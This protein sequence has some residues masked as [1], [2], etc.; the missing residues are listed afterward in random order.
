MFQ[1]CCAFTAFLYHWEETQ[2]LKLDD[3]TESLWKKVPSHDGCF[4]QEFFELLESEDSSFKKISSGTLYDTSKVFEEKF[5]SLLKNEGIDS[6]TT[7]NWA[8]GPFNPVTISDHKN[9]TTESKK[10]IQLA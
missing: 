4:S 7:K 8:I 5:L 9:P 6:G 3:E 2:T 1:S 10:V